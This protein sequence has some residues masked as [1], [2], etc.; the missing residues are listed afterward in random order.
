MVGDGSILLSRSEF[1]SAVFARDGGTCLMCPAPAVDAHHIIERRL[2]PDGGYYLSNGASLCEEHHLD[3]ERTIISCED[4]RGAA[5]IEKVLLPPHFYSD[6]RY[7][8]WGN[9][10]R[11]DGSRTPGELFWDES[12]QTA[13]RAGGVPNCW[14]M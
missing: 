9:P 10:Y 6:L 1:Q 11:E 8:K 7:D 12:V 3:A 14:S 13:L 4:L 5:G 2:W